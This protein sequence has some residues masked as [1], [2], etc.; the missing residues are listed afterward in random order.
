M[1]GSTSVSRRL[2][3]CCLNITCA[4]TSPSRLALRR[5]STSTPMFPA[6]LFHS[7]TSRSPF[8][9]LPPSATTR[10]SLVSSLINTR[11]L[12]RQYSFVSSLLPSTPVIFL[13]WSTQ[14]SISISIWTVPSRT[15]L[16]FYQ[17]CWLCFSTVDIH[18]RSESRSMSLIS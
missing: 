2:Y 9:L 11:Q 15:L 6:F 12:P 7:L 5:M 16:R 18:R 8:Q 17:S 10:S 1:A 3:C 14:N 13:P 4:S